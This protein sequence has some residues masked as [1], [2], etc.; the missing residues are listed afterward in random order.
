MQ[1]AH[2]EEEEGALRKTAPRRWEQWQ[3]QEAH[4]EE[5][6]GALRKTAPRR[7]EQWQVQVAHLEEE[8]GA[9]G[10][11]T[12]EDGSNGRCRWL[13]GG[14]GGSI[15]EHYPRRWE[16]WQSWRCPK[17]GTTWTPS[18]SVCW[19]RVT[20]TGTSWRRRPGKRPPMLTAR[21]ALSPQ[22]ANGPQLGSPITEGRRGRRWRMGSPRGDSRDPTLTP[23]SCL[24]AAWTWPSSVRTRRFT[25]SAGLGCA[26]APRCGSQSARP[27]LPQLPGRRMRRELRSPTV[28]AETCT[29]CRPPPPPALLGKPPAP[30]SP[31][32][33]GQ[34]ARRPLKTR[35]P[36]QPQPCPPSST[37]TWSAG[38]ASG[39]G[40]RRLPIGTSC[41]T[42]RA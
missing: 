22:L 23:S 8:E 5:E 2:L 18:C 15:G 35:P 16:Q 21:T 31:P 37:A 39:R 33:F 12:P 41:G 13:L 24:T 27:A 10:S 42:P 9:L 25:P 30:G 40:G 14:G 29:S 36:R 32:H 38:N 7:W 1:E 26:T 28:R 3:V 4:L 19:R 6:E 20:W 17:P 34:R 11:T